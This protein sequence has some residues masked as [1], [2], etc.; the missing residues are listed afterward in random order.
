MRLFSYEKNFWSGKWKNLVWMIYKLILVFVLKRWYSNKRRQ[1]TVSNI[2]KKIFKVLTSLLKDDILIK[3]PKRATKWFALWKLNRTTNYVKKRVTV[4][5][6]QAK[7]H[8]IFRNSMQT[9]LANWDFILF[10]QVQ[11]GFWFH[12]KQSFLWRV[13]SWLR[14]NAGGVPNTCKSSA[15]SIQKPS[16]GRMWN[17]RR[18]GE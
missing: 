12:Q 18:T 5:K 4:F 10:A 3:S 8:I 9:F 17:E 6:K 15:G 2:L 11:L 13:W 16:G 1:K 14:T 7:R